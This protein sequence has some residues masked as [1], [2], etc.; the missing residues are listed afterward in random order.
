MDMGLR[1]DV[2]IR[3]LRYNVTVSLAIPYLCYIGIPESRNCH[4]YF[5][6]LTNSTVSE[7]SLVR[8]RD[9]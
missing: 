9:H 7:T 3:L 8:K 1:M 5:P 2:D 6:T 4:C